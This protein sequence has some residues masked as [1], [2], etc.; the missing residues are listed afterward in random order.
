MRRAVGLARTAV[1]ECI[2]MFAARN[3]I[4][5]PQRTLDSC[6]EMHGPLLHDVLFFNPRLQP[7]LRRRCTRLWA[8]VEQ[9]LRSPSRNLRMT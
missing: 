2:T 3:R 7:E 5:Q 4:S 6:P 1:V 8:R 9:L